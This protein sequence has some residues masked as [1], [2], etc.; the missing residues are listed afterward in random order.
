MDV[1]GKMRADLKIL[2][3]AIESLRKRLG[4]TQEGMARRLGCRSVYTYIRWE[5]GRVEPPATWVIKM[6]ELCPDAATREQFLLDISGKG[7][8]IP[9]S[10]KSAAPIRETTEIR[11]HD[12]SPSRETYPDG[13][14]KPKK[15]GVPV[16][17]GHDPHR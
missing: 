11:A 1:K 6:M 17:K 7:S 16:P 8:T 12:T 9:S 3:T 15:Y 10:P 13:R 4:E 5:K 2:S 14:L